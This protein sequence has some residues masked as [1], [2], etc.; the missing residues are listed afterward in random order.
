MVWSPM[1]ASASAGP[2]STAGSGLDCNRRSTWTP[3]AERGQARCWHSYAEPGEENR[4]GDPSCKDPSQQY[5]LPSHPAG[6]PCETVNHAGQ[7]LDVEH[8]ARAA[9]RAAAAE[10]AAGPRQ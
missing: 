10:R 2:R 5:Y 8:A 4:H 7:L 9:V 1:T 3:T 6:M